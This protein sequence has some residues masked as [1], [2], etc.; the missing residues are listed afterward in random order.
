MASYPLSRVMSFDPPHIY[1][2]ELEGSFCGDYERCR[3]RGPL[4]LEN[5]TMESTV[6]T[7]FE[8]LCKQCNKSYYFNVERSV[9]LTPEG[10]IRLCIWDQMPAECLQ[11][12]AEPVLPPGWK[13]K[14]KVVR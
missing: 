6:G 14:P 8:M 13:I 7:C 12:V 4:Q 3:L 9:H 10:H 5:C 1:T 2:Y 11:T